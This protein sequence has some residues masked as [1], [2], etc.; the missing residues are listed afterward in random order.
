M[1]FLNNFN[2]TLFCFYK[3]SFKIKEKG[4]GRPSNIQFLAI[5]NLNT[6]NLK[7]ITSKVVS[8]NEKFIKENMKVVYRNLTIAP[9]STIKY[10]EK[11]K[12]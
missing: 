1:L 4:L 10:T 2:L 8:F 6:F 3:F 7:G 9:N 5:F 11:G 12:A